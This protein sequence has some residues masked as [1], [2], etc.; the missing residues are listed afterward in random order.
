VQWTRTAST[1]FAGG[2]L[3]FDGSAWNKCTVSVI[4]AARA[5]ILYVMLEAYEEMLKSTRGAPAANVAVLQQIGEL[6][7]VDMIAKNMGGVLES[8]VLQPA[9]VCDPPV[10]ASCV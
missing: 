6:W 5:H 4:A 8:G 9:E 7:G 10:S 2:K 3:V 1:C